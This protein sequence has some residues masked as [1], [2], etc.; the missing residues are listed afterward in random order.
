MGLSEV[1]YCLKDQKQAIKALE[2]AIGQITR[3]RRAG[4]LSAEHM[5]WHS[6]TWTLLEDVFGQDSYVF[7]NFAS[8]SFQYRGSFITRG[9]GYEAEV[10]Q[11]QNEGFNRDL[12]VSLGLLQ[13]GIDQ[14]RKK[15]IEHVYEGKNT[16]PES[17]EILKILS[18]IDNKLRKAMR[19]TPRKESEVLDAFETLL[20]GGGLD[21]E[22]TREKERI[23]YSSKTY[24]PDFVFRRINTAVEGKLCDSQR[25]MKE[26]ISEIND[27]I[28]AYGTKFSNRIFVVYDLGVISD[29]DQF[30][31][32]IETE[33]HVIVRIVK[34]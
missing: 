25:R 33:D 29:Q 5:R 2:Q 7:Q 16:A 11:K 14:I 6:N 4:R 18:L 19:V 10:E 13:S 21:G 15:G 32:G 20:I 17:S 28:V 31:G 9:F 1:R 24:I 30:K 27:D 12:D 22:F 8:L 3:V 23:V 26:I 34:H